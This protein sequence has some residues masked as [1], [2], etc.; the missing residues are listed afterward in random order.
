MF[1]GCLWFGIY[2][3][4]CVCCSGK[5]LLRCDFVPVFAFSLFASLSFVSVLILLSLPLVPSHHVNLP[6]SW[7]V[8]VFV[9]AGCTGVAQPADVIL[10]RPL[11]H[12]YKNQYTTWT[13]QQ[14]VADLKAGVTAED[15]QLAKDVKT[16]KPMSVKWA[17]ASW[18]KLKE[19]KDDIAKGWRKI[20]WNQMLDKDYQFRALTTLEREDQAG[21]STL[22]ADQ[23][24]E[25]PGICDYEEEEEEEEDEVAE[26]D[27]DAETE[28]VLARCIENAG[29]GATSSNR[30][31]TRQ[32]TYRD[33]NLARALQEQ[34]YD[35]F[36][37]LD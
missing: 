2:F 22:L 17:V 20:G 4:A 25:E 11:K 3:P 16:L 1:N 32:S 33:A 31:S 21:A 29:S 19:K 13:T 6:R 15:C 24:E 27:E 12:D 36:C 34:T 26:S 30:R 7:V 8:T 28:V 35:E 10:Q 14:M 37:I 23:V 18:L 9:P 5:L